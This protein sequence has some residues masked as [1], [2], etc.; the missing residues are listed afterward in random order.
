MNEPCTTPSAC[1]YH[2]DF[3]DITE[4]GNC[5]FENVVDVV[6]AGE[7]I[8]EL[9]EPTV[10]GLSYQNLSSSDSNVCSLSENNS[11]SPSDTLPEQIGTLQEVNQEQQYKLQT[12][13]SPQ[14]TPQTETI[15]KKTLSAEIFTTQ[16]LQRQSCRRELQNALAPVQVKVLAEKSKME[17][18]LTMWEK[19][20]C[21]KN[22]LNSPTYGVMKT[23]N[24][25]SVFLKKSSMHKHY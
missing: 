1:D 24:K 11:K 14:K 12:P 22:N 23:D 19:D 18:E 20:Y 15:E 4:S 13:W 25:A 8:V 2:N 3:S 9:N 5:V 6:P 7:E 10:Q 16:W 17:K 21:L